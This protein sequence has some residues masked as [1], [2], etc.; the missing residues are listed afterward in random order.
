MIVTIGILTAAASGLVFTS[1]YLFGARRGSVARR[2]LEG[3]CKRILQRSQS[4]DE[5]VA[6]LTRAAAADAAIRAH[7]AGAVRSIEQRQDGSVGELRAELHALAAAVNDRERKESALRTELREELRAL[8]K[9]GGDSVRIERELRRIVG[10]L[11]E[12]QTD[13]RGL[14]EMVSQALA[15]LLEKERLGRE[16]AQLEVGASLSELPRMLDA[17][18]QKGSFSSV[19]LSDDVG[20]PLAAS[21]NAQSVDWLAGM[22]SLVLTLVERSERSGA[23]RPIGVVVHD[24]ANQRLLHRVFRAGGAHFLLTAVSRGQ[25]VN[26]SALDPALGN[27]ERALSR[28]EIQA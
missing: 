1:G 27:L 14:R 22:A 10:P 11:L 6:A 3:D 23:P 19:V 20:L 4:L 25:D 15:P 7:L 2:M 12:R 21:A 16:L 28:P 5:R 13:T 26:P 9:N 8:A 17:I 18:A 24:E